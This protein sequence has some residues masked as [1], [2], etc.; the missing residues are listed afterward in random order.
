M[1]GLT[2]TVVQSLGGVGDSEGVGGW[3]VSNVGWS[4]EKSQGNV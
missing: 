4:A 3:V 2:L 1:S